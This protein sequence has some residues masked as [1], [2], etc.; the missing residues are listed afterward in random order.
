MLALPGRT[1]RRGTRYAQERN[2]VRAR[3]GKYAARVYS[4]VKNR[5]AKNEP[6]VSAWFDFGSSLDF[7]RAVRLEHEGSSWFAH[8]EVELHTFRVAR[9]TLTP[10]PVSL[11]NCA[12][13]S[14]AHGAFNVSA[15][16]SIP[17][18]VTMPHGFD[19]DPRLW[20]FLDTRAPANSSANPFAPRAEKHQMEWD[21]FELSGDV[22]GMRLR[23]QNNFLVSPTDVFYPDLWTPP[24]RRTRSTATRACT[25]RSP[26]RTSRGARRNPP[27]TTSPPSSRKPSL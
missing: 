12:F 3:F 4:D 5:G 20:G 26:G 2:H 1:T 6:E 25:S 14:N 13:H 11:R 9:E 22:L 17:T 21:V 19:A 16:R 18:I 8:E 24:R 7:G 23:Y 15:H 27:S 10:C